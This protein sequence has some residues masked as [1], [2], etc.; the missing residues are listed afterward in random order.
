[1]HFQKRYDTYFIFTRINPVNIKTIDKNIDEVE[2]EDCSSI[3]GQ[4]EWLYSGQSLCIITKENKIAAIGGEWENTENA[5]L[6]WK[7]L[8]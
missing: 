7:I 4:F 6:T 3:K 2:K 5:E 8:S 1:M